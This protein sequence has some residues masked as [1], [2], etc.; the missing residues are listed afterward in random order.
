MNPLSGWTNFYVIAGSSAGALIGLQFVSLTLIAQRPVRDAR[1][2]QIAGSAFATPTVLHFSAV[3]LL[4]GTLSAPW[5]AVTSAAIAWGLVGG[6]GV[7]Y[8]LLVGR[9]MTT[10]KA[11][12]P[13]LEDWL[14]H[15]VVPLAAYATLPI[16]AAFAGAHASGALFA[17]AAA[18]L[19]LLFSAIHNAWDAVTYHIY[20]LGAWERE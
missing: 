8:E 15:F 4:S 2:L 5:R 6:C 16:S 10:Q 20:T 18:V 17:V 14:F 7:G 12:Q 19:A 13:Q 3:L 9:R 1:P 11:Y